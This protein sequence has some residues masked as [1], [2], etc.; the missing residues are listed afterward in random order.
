M[1]TGEVVVPADEA[2]CVTGEPAVRTAEALLRTGEE[3][4]CRLGAL[5]AVGY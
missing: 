2:L 5:R 1:R 4:E 3:V